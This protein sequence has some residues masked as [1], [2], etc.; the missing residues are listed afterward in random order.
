MGGPPKPQTLAAGSRGDVPWGQLQGR[1]ERGA[2]QVH[3]QGKK[4]RSVS[5]ARLE[6]VWVTFAWMVFLSLGWFTHTFKETRERGNQETFKATDPPGST[7]DQGA[8]DNCPVMLQTAVAFAQKS[9][10]FYL[11]MPVAKTFKIL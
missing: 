4:D 2:F 11:P 5:H 6:S 8:L 9:S 7:T 3:C 1:V 10:E